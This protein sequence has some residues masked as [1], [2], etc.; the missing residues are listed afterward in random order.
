MVVVGPPACVVVVG[1]PACVVVDESAALVL[2]A[3]AAS[4]LAS[5]ILV[6]RLADALYLWLLSLHVLCLELNT[7]HFFFFMLHFFPLQPQLLCI[8]VLTSSH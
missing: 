4:F 1:P 3:A 6:A 8:P 7:E 2:V 5:A